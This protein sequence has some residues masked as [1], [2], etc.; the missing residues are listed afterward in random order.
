VIYWIA[1]IWTLIAAIQAHN[2]LK[3]IET[4]EKFKEIID[5]HPTIPPQ[6]M[7]SLLCIIVF[8]D[9]FLKWWYYILLF[10]IWLPLKI[11]IVIRLLTWV[12]D[13]G[14]SDSKKRFYLR[15]LKIIR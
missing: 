8:I 12:T 14:V 10:N 6:V 15:V 3:D 1:I 4:D 2:D 7:W 9:H 13:D 5:A 11:K